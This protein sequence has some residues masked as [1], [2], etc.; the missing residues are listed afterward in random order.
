MHLAPSAACSF[1]MIAGT[2]PHPFLATR[3]SRHA[4]RADDLV[5]GLDR[6]SA[7]RRDDPRQV[8]R[9]GCGIVLY[10][11]DK[12]ARWDAKRAR[13]VG[14]ALAVLHRFRRSAVAAHRDEDL[15]ITPEHMDGD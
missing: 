5:A 3:R 11:L 9:A 10:A 13:S 4:D 12:F 8:H 15:A 14:L 1:S 6:Q 7:L 2:M